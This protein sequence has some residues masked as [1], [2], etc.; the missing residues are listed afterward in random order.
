MKD[1]SNNTEWKVGAII[2]IKNWNSLSI[3]TIKRE[4]KNYWIVDFNDSCE[5]KIRKSD[6]CETRGDIWHRYEW[7]LLTTDEYNKIKLEK[8]KESL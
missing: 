6:H 4:T 7:N 8:A 3:R 2:Y 5:G 1:L